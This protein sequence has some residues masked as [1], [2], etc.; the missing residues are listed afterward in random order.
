MPMPEEAPKLTPEQEVLQ[1]SRNE[2]E[3]W[4]DIENIAEGDP[5]GVY[6]DPKDILYEHAI[7]EDKSRDQAG[8]NA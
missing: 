8:N 3:R 2:E 1:A 5:S 7:E 6:G 4:A